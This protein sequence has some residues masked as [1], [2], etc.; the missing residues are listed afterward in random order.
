MV[1]A[2]FID[3]ISGLPIVKLLDETT[4][5]TMVIKLKFIQNLATLD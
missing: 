3:E 1:D 5:S 2:P 4:H